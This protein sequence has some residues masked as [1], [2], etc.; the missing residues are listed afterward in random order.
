[1]YALVR[2]VYPEGR[3]DG[4]PSESEFLRLFGP[5]LE[6]VRTERGSW[7]SLGRRCIGQMQ[8][9]GADCLTMGVNVER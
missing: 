7:R 5:G 9:V 2:V 3:M 8:E 6:L 1:M 4:P